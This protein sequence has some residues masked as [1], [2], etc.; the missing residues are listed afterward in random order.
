MSPLLWERLGLTR[1]DF[2]GIEQAMMVEN[3]AAKARSLVTPPMLRI[4]I[5]GT[6]HDLIERLEVLV[7]LG[8]RHLS[9][10]PP[11]GPDPLAALAA[12]GRDVLPHFKAIS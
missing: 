10:G 11:L 5:A 12:I 4:G 2:A 1:A 3:D 7:S 9:L 8:V 6:T